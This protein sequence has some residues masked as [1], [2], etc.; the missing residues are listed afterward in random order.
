LAGCF[1]NSGSLKKPT[2][3]NVYSK[4]V[5]FLNEVKVELTKVSWSSRQEL[6]G[7]TTVVIVLT[8]LIALFIFIIDFM[9]AKILSLVFKA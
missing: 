3:M 6:M 1:N 8:S 7:S 2:K 5:N 4:T 9:L